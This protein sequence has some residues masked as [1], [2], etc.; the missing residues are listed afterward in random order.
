MILTSAPAKYFSGVVEEFV[1]V[2]F[3]SR[4]DVAVHTLVVVAAILLMILF[5]AIVDGLFAFL[6]KLLF[7]NA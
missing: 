7:T 6:L 2:S 3:P 1:K 4:R 5:L